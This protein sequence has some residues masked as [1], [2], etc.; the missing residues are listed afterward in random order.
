[1]PRL[2]E[3]K[4]FHLIFFFSPSRTGTILQ[5]TAWTHSQLQGVFWSGR[6]PAKWCCSPDQSPLCSATLKFISSLFNLLNSGV[7]FVGRKGKGRKPLF[8]PFKDPLNKTLTGKQRKNHVQRF[9]IFY[10]SQGQTL[11][12]IIW[13]SFLSSEV[14]GIPRMAVLY[15]SFFSLRLEANYFTLWT[16]SLSPKENNHTGPPSSQV[17]SGGSRD[18]VQESTLK[19]MM[20]NNCSFQKECVC[21]RNNYHLQPAGLPHHGKFSDALKGQRTFVFCYS[22]NFLHI[23]LVGVPILS[24]WGCNF[25]HY[26]QENKMHCSLSSVCL[27]SGAITVPYAVPGGW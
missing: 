14:M 26:F 11:G 8:L 18:E 9:I 20:K 25:A 6:H 16:C 4:W 5:A 27:R 21:L 19:C 1:M 23:D 15:A 12:R 13:V 10:Q 22:H 24:H 17:C 7:A 3:C 2:L